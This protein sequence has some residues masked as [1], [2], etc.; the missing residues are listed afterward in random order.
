MVAKVRVLIL[1][2]WDIADALVL[3]VVRKETKPLE[4]VTFSK[5]HAALVMWSLRRDE[6]R[7]RKDTLESSYLGGMIVKRVQDIGVV[8]AASIVF[9]SAK[10]SV[11]VAEKEAKEKVDLQVKLEMFLK[12]Y[13][14]AKVEIAQ[15]D[16]IIAK[17]KNQLAGQY[18]R[19]ESST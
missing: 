10:F 2:E 6:S 7:K 16:S 18:Q 12:G 9:K 5:D 17:L 19:G 14:E 13:N 11:V 3:E 4:G 1:H 8:E 15:R